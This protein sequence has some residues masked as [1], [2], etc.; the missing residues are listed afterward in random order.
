MAK[1]D[2]TKTS[3]QITTAAAVVAALIMF[4]GVLGVDWPLTERSEIIQQGVQF[5]E[6]QDLE[7]MKL[8]AEIRK[9]NMAT[10]RSA[11]DSNRY[12]LTQYDRPSLT[13]GDIREKVRLE[14]EIER[15]QME[16]AEWSKK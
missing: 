10:L 8:N 3:H 9:I 4:G 16:L 14:G 13:A 6:I 1:L 2:L 11:I 5:D 7:V 15:F 12:I